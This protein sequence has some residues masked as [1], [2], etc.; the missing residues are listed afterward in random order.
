[1]EIFKV[2][3]GNKHSM[4]WESFLD[5][6]YISIFQICL[7]PNEVQNVADSEKLERLSVFFFLMLASGY[8][9]QSCDEI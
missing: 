6:K 5:Y 8:Q 9:E 7:S 3:L 2:N 4:S 1:M